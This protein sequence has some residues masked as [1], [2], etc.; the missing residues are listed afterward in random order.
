[1]QSVQVVLVHVA[2]LVSASG[3]GPC[4]G[5]IFAE[6]IYKHKS[7]GALLVILVIYDTRERHTV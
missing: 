7:P 1:M 3:N 2:D 5:S 4:T 6:R